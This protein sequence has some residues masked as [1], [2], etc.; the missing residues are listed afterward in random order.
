MDFKILKAVDEKY[1]KGM[2]NIVIQSPDQE[3][4][5][6][7]EEEIIDNELVASHY[8]TNND[9]GYHFFKSEYVDE[10]EQENKQL[11]EKLG[12]VLQQLHITNEQLT[13][14][15]FAHQALSDSQSSRE[16]EKK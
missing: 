7:V 8:K 9:N 3:Q 16:V 11:K 10:L 6:N 2:L 15:V 12:E 1:Y 13:N 14:I 4:A 5:D